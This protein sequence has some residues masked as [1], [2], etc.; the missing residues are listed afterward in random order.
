[1]YVVQC[2]LYRWF[3]GFDWEKL[4]NLSLTPPFSQSINGPLDT[5]NFDYFPK[6]NEST[7]DEISGWDKVYTSLFAHLF[8]NKIKK[9]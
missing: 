1:M 8:K 6:E 2:T 5:S 4:A 3:Q 9:I 7:S